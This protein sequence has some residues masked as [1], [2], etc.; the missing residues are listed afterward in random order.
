RA[1]RGVSKVTCWNVGSMERVLRSASCCCVK[2]DPAYRSANHSADA[3]S[4]A[5]AR[6]TRTAIKSADRFDLFIRS[7]LEETWTGRC[8]RSTLTLPRLISQT[9][10]LAE[11][12]INR[13]GSASA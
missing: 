1:R 4:G 11:H 2:A 7:L 10:W 12:L 3:G 13:R 5:W 9:I 8:S 6:T